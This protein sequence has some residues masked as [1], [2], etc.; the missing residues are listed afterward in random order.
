VTEE[1]ELK[2]RLYKMHQDAVDEFKDKPNVI[3]TAASRNIIASWIDEAKKELLK[4]ADFVVHCPTP[5]EEY[6]AIIIPKK[7]F[8]KWF[9]DSS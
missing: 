6:N 7:D 8:E 3:V 1:G 5:T 2:K 4:K 9:G